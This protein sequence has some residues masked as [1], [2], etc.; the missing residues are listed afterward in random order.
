MKRK[1]ILEILKGHCAGVTSTKENG[2]FAT[3]VY[4]DDLA[5]ELVNL[6]AIHNVLKQSEQLLAVAKYVYWNYDESSSKKPEDYLKDYK[7]QLT[8]TDVSQ[9]GELLMRDRLLK[10]REETARVREKTAIQN[11]LE[12]YCDLEELPTVE[13]VLKR[14]GRKH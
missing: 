10:S 12:I 1:Q 9:Q 14:I 5:D 13:E 4:L 11:T 8:S 2:L 3:K 7:K 6:F